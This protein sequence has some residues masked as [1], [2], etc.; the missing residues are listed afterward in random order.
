MTRL[1][2]RYIG[3]QVFVSAL[4]AVLIILIILI[5]GNVFKDILR[6]LADRPDLDLTFVLKF[7][8][9]IIP[10]ALGIAI[11]F[12]FLTAI[13]LTF[14]K[15]SADS[16]LVSMRM[17]GLSLARIC[18]PISVIA[19][20]F[21]ALCAWINLSVTPWSKAQLEGMKDTMINKAKRDPM[22]MFKD[23][24]VMNDF[25]GY[26]LHANKEDGVLK[27]FMMVQNTGSEVDLVT[28]AKQAKLRVDFECNQLLVELDDANILKINK[29]SAAQ[30]GFITNGETAIPLDKFAT[31]DTK[32]QP[33]NLPL[34]HLLHLITKGP[35][36]TP[37]KLSDQVLTE[38]RV[39][40]KPEIKATLKTE[41]SMRMAFSVSCL[42]FALIGV[43]LGISAQR[44][45][46]TAGFVLALVIAVSYYFLLNMAKLRSEDPTVHP[47]LLVWIPNILCLVLG[48]FL[49]IR[50]SRK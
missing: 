44:R 21:T 29:T 43:P 45:E 50:V 10:F 48:V 36:D 12:S 16:E 1:L 31:S 6:E 30:P 17:A 8:G 47:H 26:L 20:L 19:I 40:L 15:L 13:L 34:L 2:D 41:L 14:G 18:L 4:F 33:E 38:D 22:F 3:R 42:M 11:P 32:L 35:I 25:K 46:T 23:E 39:A 37:V 7:V 27:N 5:L 49:F 24:Q 28:F 9:L